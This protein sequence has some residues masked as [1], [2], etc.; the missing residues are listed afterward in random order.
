MPLPPIVFPFDPALRSVADLT[1]S[2]V[3]RVPDNHEVEERYT[4]DGNGIVSVAIRD[5]SDGYEVTRS[6]GAL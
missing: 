2:A 3:V 5:L 1:N 6:L 4:V